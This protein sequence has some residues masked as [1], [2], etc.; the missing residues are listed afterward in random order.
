MVFLH[1]EPERALLRR[2]IEMVALHGDE[3]FSIGDA[4]VD[5]GHGEGDGVS[6]GAG[7]EEDVA[8]EFALGFVADGDA[9]LEQ[10]C[11]D[12]WAGVEALGLVANFAGDFELR[13]GFQVFPGEGFH[14]AI[15]QGDL[16]GGCGEGG[17]GEDGDGGDDREEEAHD[18]EYEPR[19][20]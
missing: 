11:L 4:G 17:R 5:F 20:G 7:G 9:A 13:Q 18:G 12:G 6:V 14:F 10:K 15:G 19:E 3:D 16:E 1:G 8:Q 2:Q